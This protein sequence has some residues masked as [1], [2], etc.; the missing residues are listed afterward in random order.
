[1]REGVKNGASECGIY[2]AV[3]GFGGALWGR[4]EKF[5][6]YVMGDDIIFRT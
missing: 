1:M 3:C 4:C 5:R 2:F 6:L